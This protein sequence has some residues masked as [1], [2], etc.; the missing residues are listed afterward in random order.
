MACTIWSH[1]PT[2]GTMSRYALSGLLADSLPTLLVGDRYIRAYITP[3]W[4]PSVNHAHRLFGSSRPIIA[5]VSSLKRIS[6]SWQRAG[7]AFVSVALHLAMLALMLMSP[8]L[9]TVRSPAPLAVVVLLEERKPQIVLPALQPPNLR[10]LQPVKIS[11]VPPQLFTPTSAGAAITTSDASGSAAAPSVP[12][13]KIEQSADAKA[14]AVNYSAMVSARLS[15]EKAYPPSAK[16]LHEE[17]VVLLIVTIERSG[18]VLQWRIGQGS[19]VAALDEEV[20]QMINAIPLFPPFPKSMTQ[21]L[22][23]FSVPVEFSLIQHE[24]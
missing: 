3:A 18:R 22:E 1:D 2:M 8:A 11:D 14:A 24:S 12:K 17:G 7:I 23:T 16:R 15:A 9:H 5:P 19:G 13:P 6:W 4:R 10:A 20:T 21:E